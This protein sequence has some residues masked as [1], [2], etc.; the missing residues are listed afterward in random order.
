MHKVHNK[1]NVNILNKDRICIPDF[2]LLSQAPVKLGLVLAKMSGPGKFS[3][4]VVIVIFRD[5]LFI[6]SKQLYC[7]RHWGRHIY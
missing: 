4:N 7:I 1:Q 5:I 2:F 3:N 6:Y